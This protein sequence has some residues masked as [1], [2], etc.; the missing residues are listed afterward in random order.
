MKKELKV[1]IDKELDVNITDGDDLTG[2]LKQTKPEVLRRSARL[3]QTEEEEQNER[4]EV[5]L[6]KR[7]PPPQPALNV[8]L[9][10]H[11][12]MSKEELERLKANHSKTAKHVKLQGIQKY[13]EKLDEF[14]EDNTAGPEKMRKTMRE[15]LSSLSTIVRGFKTRKLLKSERKRKPSS[16][17]NRIKTLFNGKKDRNA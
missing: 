6:P 5:K 12:T 11:P 14:V 2:V 15:T 16:I 1:V 9:S 13:Y 8:K 3:T 7:T 17:L 10:E 4:Y